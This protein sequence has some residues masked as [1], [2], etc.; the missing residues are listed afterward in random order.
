MPTNKYVKGKFRVRTA[1]HEFFFSQRRVNACSDRGGLRKIK[2]IKISSYSIQSPPIPMQPNS[3]NLHPRTRR[4]FRIFYKGK[5]LEL[6]RPFS[7][8]RLNSQLLQ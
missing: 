3:S 1:V 7:D 2:K 6:F 5:P 8:T 4:F